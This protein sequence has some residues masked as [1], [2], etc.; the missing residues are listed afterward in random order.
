MI[1]RAPEPLYL[2]DLPE[3]LPVRLL[4]KKR[5]WT[6]NHE[7]QKREIFHFGCEFHE[8][9]FLKRIFN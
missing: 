8:T 2:Q 9:H 6:D 7:Q 4:R 5:L 3:V 1:A